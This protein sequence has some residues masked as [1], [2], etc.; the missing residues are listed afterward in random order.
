MVL[1]V[2]FAAT[3]QAQDVH[4]DHI[5]PPN[6][7]AGMQHDQVQLMVYGNNLQ[8][9]TAS[10][11]DDAL[12]VKVV[13]SLANPTYSFIDVDFSQA[14]AGTYTLRLTG[15]D[16]EATIDFPVYERAPLAGRNQG[17]GVDDVVYL[18][19]P[20]RFTNG[21]PSNDRAA[22][23]IDDFDPSQ[24]G[25]RHGGDLQGIQARLP[26]LAD[27][28]ITA[29]WLNPILENNA[30]NSYH[31][32]QATNYYKI[33][34]RHGGN[35]A[36]KDFVAAAHR[37]GI[38]VIFDHVNNHIGV[39]HV[40]VD[41]LPTA[42]WL[43][44]SKEDHLSSKHYKMAFSDPYA[45]PHADDLLRT[46]WFVDAM[47][48]VNQRDPYVAKY[49]IQNSIWWMEYTGLDGYRED[50]YPYPD[51]DFLADW[52]AAILQ[53]Y[54]RSNIV[55]E[56]WETEPAYLSLFQKETHFERDFETNLPTIMDFALTDA[57]R[58]YL[59][60]SVR[61]DAVYKVLA[62]DFVYTDRNNLFTFF[63]N[64]DM[65]RGYFIADGN[66]KK[67]KQVFTMLLTTRGIP[68][69]LYGS[70]HNMRG[71]QSHIELRAN[72]PGGFPGDTRDVFTEAG[73]TEMEN[74]MFS[75]VRT[76]L[77]LRKK[78]D[79][80]RHGRLVHYPVAWNES[81]YKYL[82]MDDDEKI[83]V[84]INGEDDNKQVDLSE[85]LHWF[86]AEA[87]FKNLVTDEVMQ[88]NANA[89]LTLSPLGAYVLQVVD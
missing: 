16:S 32:Y 1:L 39:H 72:M 20:D 63:D 38:K 30:N 37:H 9:I 84:L 88:M 52:A 36:Y 69:M 62:Q 55:G 73:R 82:R 45:D 74:D 58:K 2:S 86:G 13:H 66:V 31:G 70:E 51:Q 67:M 77:H 15:K 4:I 10:F 49:L 83:L 24:H 87:S 76:L 33:D 46:F 78:H 71:G 85:L 60:G 26:Y 7:W 57:W 6:W 14:T 40:W 44:G 53:E 17:F 22:G 59:E 5:E 23:M 28:G 34:P 8:G 47:P 56:I 27:L 19:T 12:P 35:E 64:H 54:P 68:Q 89:Q 42:T 11:D 18:I 25:T 81:V 79:V 50:T 75:F 48:D 29:V 41:N 80:L 43:N 21:D 3:V 61:L 65:A